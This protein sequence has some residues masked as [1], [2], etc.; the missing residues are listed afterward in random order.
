MSSFDTSVFVDTDALTIWGNEFKNINN[1]SIENIE[2]FELKVK[3][4][5]LD[6]RGNSAESFC[7]VVSESMIQA[8]EY[9]EKMNDISSFLQ[10]VIETMEKQ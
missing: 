5:G 8:K 2:N 10:L 9:H 3:E 6:F 4:L 1:A 7:S